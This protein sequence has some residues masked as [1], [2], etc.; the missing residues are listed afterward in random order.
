M[1]WRTGL[2]AVAELAVRA[3]DR[4][5]GTA[6]HGGV[7]PDGARSGAGTAARW[8]RAGAGGHQAARAIRVR[9]AGGR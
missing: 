4:A 3:G 2:V 7:S 1:W 6:P 9:M 8:V 5:S